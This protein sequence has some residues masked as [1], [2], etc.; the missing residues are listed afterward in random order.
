MATDGD[1]ARKRQLGTGRSTDGAYTES[2]STRE[3]LQGLLARNYLQP[4]QDDVAASSGQI[5]D[6]LGSGD[7]VVTIPMREQGP[8]VRPVLDTL[9][10]LMPAEAILVIND[11]S[12]D[13]AAQEVMHHQGVQMCLRSEILDTIDWDKLLPVLNLAERPYGMGKGLCVLAGYLFHYYQSVKSGRTP[14]WLCQ[15]DAEIRMYQDYRA[16]EY[17]IYGLLERPEAVYAKIAKWGRTNERC[18]ALRSALWVIAESPELPELIRGRARQMFYRLVAHKWMLTGEF[19]LSWK[20]AMTRPFATGYLEETLTSMFVEDVASLNGNSAIHVANPNPRLDADNSERKEA[21]MQQQ[22]GDFVLMMAFGAGPVNHWTIQDIT[23]LNA[24]CMSRPIRMGWI[25]NDEGPV[26]AED[27]PND[28]ILPSVT[29]LVD[30]GF[31]DVAKGLE[32]LK[33]EN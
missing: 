28:R 17:L 7:V 8:V 20:L 23:S 21:L 16:M 1:D 6:F 13:L 31:V 33:E 14:K 12:S 19:I 27:L 15:H 29:M 11:S 18:M 24:G 32:A 26:V 30:G 3:D 5:Q 22:I 10:R 2:N 4:N 25:P 9:C